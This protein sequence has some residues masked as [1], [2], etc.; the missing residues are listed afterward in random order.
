[1]V[2]AGMNPKIIVGVIGGAT[3]LLGLIG[4]FYPEQAMHMVGYGYTNP[5]NRPGTLGEVRAIYGGL[6]LMAGV[7]TLL[8]APDPRANQGRLVLLGLLWLGAC[9][10]RLLGVFID[11]NPGVVGWLAAASELIGGGGLLFAS[12][13]APST[14]D[15]SL[16]GDA[17][18]LIS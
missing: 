9:G 18:P 6:T 3:V 12:Q 16:D 5:E 14:R 2:G 13:A 10:G 4:I 11:G 7:I 8:A 17:A 1:M 15:A